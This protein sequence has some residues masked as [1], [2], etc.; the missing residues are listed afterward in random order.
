MKLCEKG[1]NQTCFKIHWRYHWNHKQQRSLSHHHHLKKKRFLFGSYWLF[2]TQVSTIDSW[3]NVTYRQILTG[4]WKQK[5]MA[6]FVLFSIYFFLKYLHF[7]PCGV[8][9]SMII[10]IDI[11][12]KCIIVHKL[13]HIGNQNV[14]PLYNEKLENKIFGLSLNWYCKLYNQWNFT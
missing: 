11:V 10:M 2:Y 13:K 8:G 6:S 12:K 1:L 3:N 7:Y 4:S 14:V 9:K 5:K